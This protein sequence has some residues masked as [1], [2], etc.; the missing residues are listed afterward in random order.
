MTLHFP[1]EVET[2]L[3]T[4]NATDP[5]SGT[6][7]FKAT[8]IRVDR[9]RSARRGG[10]GGATPRRSRPADGPRHPERAADGG[11]ARGR[12][13]GARPAAV[14]L[15]GRRAGHRPR[16]ARGTRR[17][18]RARAAPPAAPDAARAPVARRLDQ[19]RGAQLRLP[20]ADDPA[21]R[22]VRR[23]V[24]LRAVLARAAAAGRGPRVHRRRLHRRAARRSSSRTSSGPSVPRAAPRQ[25]PG[26]VAR[27][28][29]PG[30]V[31]ARARRDAHRGGPRAARGVG[32]AGRRRRHRGHARERRGAAAAGAARPAG[33][34]P[35]AAA[36]APRRRG[37]PG[38][39]R[40]LP[41]PRRLRGAA[42]RRRDGAGP[43]AARGDGL[44][45]AGPRRRGV[46][47]RT[48][49]GGGRTQRQAPALPDLQRRRVRAGHVQG[50]RDPRARPVLRSSRR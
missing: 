17:A 40:Q 50:P 26:G 13:R 4:I 30:D 37:R 19:P 47:D 35:V 27:E 25:R 41:R 2:N 16:P 48:Q 7:E 15:G 5:K 36:A 14:E 24:V 38:E 1:D 29:V 3:L 44:Q 33:R 6:A 31:R 18:C 39:H 9:I 20:A 22:G 32:R 21:G 43:R 8:A 45:A 34:R 49:V 12:R 28:P 42:R 46:P 10:G 23:G 11:G